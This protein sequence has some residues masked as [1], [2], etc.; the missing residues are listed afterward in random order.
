MEFY[1]TSFFMVVNASFRLN[2]LEIFPCEFLYC[3]PE[4]LNPKA[5]PV[6]AFDLADSPSIFFYD[7]PGM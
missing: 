1:V 4:I 3:N 5:S 7:E 2:F 6:D